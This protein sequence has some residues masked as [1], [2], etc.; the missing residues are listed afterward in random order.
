MG[1]WCAWEIV[2]HL[3]HLRPRTAWRRLSRDGAEGSVGGRSIRVWYPSTRSLERAFSPDFTL[4]RVLGVGVFLPP[5]YLWEAVERRRWL[6]RGLRR[7]E[8]ALSG[9]PV[10]R[11]LGDHVLFDFERTPLPWSACG[12]GIHH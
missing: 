4:Q 7:I 11:R 10:V 6:L 3:L 2:W 9:L 8:G 1:R 12:D 5:T